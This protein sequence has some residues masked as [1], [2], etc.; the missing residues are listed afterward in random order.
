MIKLDKYFN[1][2]N[3]RAVSFPICWLNISIS[4]FVIESVTAFKD[5]L[6]SFNWFSNSKYVFIRSRLLRVAMRVAERVGGKI[7]SDF[8]GYPFE[9]HS[10]NSP[11]NFSAN[12]INSSNDGMPL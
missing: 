5:V 7:S 10:L 11:S 1:G 8:C 6:A 3:S 2:P 4:N 9:I 12:N